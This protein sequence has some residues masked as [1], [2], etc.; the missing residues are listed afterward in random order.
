MGKDSD[1]STKETINYF[2]GLDIGSVSLNTV[3]LDGIIMSLRTIMI[4][5]TGNHLMC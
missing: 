4:M 1:H 2:L 5:F 3:I